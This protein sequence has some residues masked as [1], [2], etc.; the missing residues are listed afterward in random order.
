VE[1]KYRVSVEKVGSTD[2]D[3]GFSL[4]VSHQQ[5][6]DYILPLIKDLQAQ[7]EKENK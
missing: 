1:Q 2:K 4:T 5:Y 3:A 7:K 6:L